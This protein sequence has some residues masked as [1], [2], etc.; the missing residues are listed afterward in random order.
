MDNN[1]IETLRNDNAITFSTKPGIY[2][3]TETVNPGM[4]NQQKVFKLKGKVI[5]GKPTVI[6]TMRLDAATNKRFRKAPSLQ[7][8]LVNRKSKNKSSLKIKLSSI[9][10]DDNKNITAYLYN[11]IYTG[12][13]KIS[14]SNALKYKLETKI[15][16]ILNKVLGIIKV[17]FGKEE[18]LIGGEKRLITVY[19]DPN[20]SFKLA[21]TKITEEKDGNGDVYS[22]GEESILTV[23]KVFDSIE[24][25]NEEEVSSV[26]NSTFVNHLGEIGVINKTLDERGQYSFLQKFPL[27]TAETK[28]GINILPTTI[29][30]KFNTTQFEK[31]RIGWDGW[32]SKVLVQSPDPS[33][34]IRYSMLDNTGAPHKTIRVNGFTVQASNGNHFGYDKIYTGQ[35]NKTPTQIKA[36]GVATVTG[37][38]LLHVFEEKYTVLLDGGGTHSF[39]VVKASGPILSNINQADSNWTNSVPADNG[40]TDISIVTVSP[41]V[42]STTSTSND[43]CKFTIKYNV[44]NWGTKDT[45]YALDLNQ[46][47]TVTT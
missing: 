36:K 46:I 27:A 37:G 18:V 5:R 3:A 9:V 32:Y 25:E 4:A 19:G 43:T 16:T 1:V 42:I 38:Y 33:L 47:I 30:S 31:D 2:I 41:P 39:G 11:L 40:G 7:R 20:S 14:K 44:R 21:L 24:D 22:T 45:V 10:K 8:F 12:K 28:Y 15:E 29:S 17:K 6:A 23:P 34:T 26:A 13:E 35:Y